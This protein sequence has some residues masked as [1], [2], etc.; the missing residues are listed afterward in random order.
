MDMLLIKYISSVY[1]LQRIEEVLDTNT[2]L[3]DAEVDDTSAYLEPPNFFFFG[4]L[5]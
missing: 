1:L 2:Q 4:G 5:G 3:E